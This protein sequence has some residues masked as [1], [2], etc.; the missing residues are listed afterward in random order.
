MMVLRLPPLVVLLIFMAAAAMAQ[1]RGA[2]SHWTVENLEITGNEAFEDDELK[3]LMVTRPGGWFK[4]NK[5][6]PGLFRSDLT[7]LIDFYQSNGYLGAQ[8]VDTQ[9]TRDTADHNVRIAITVD[10]GPL[11][12]VEAISLFGNTAFTDSTLYSFIDLTAGS[13]Y[14]RRILQEGLMA[15]ASLYA[16]SGY[17]EA[18]VT[19]RTKV[20]EDV[21]RVLID[22]VIEEG[23]QMVISD[24]EI[25]GLRKTDTSVVRRELTFARGQVV[26]YSAL[27]QSQRQIYLTGLFS[28]VYI[29]PVRQPDDSVGQR[30]VVVEVGEKKNSIIQ[31]SAGYGS[32]EKV[33]GRAEISANNLA[34]TGRQAGIITEANFLER[35]VEG[36]FTEPRTFGTRFQTDVS[37]L[38][39]YMDEPG[40]DVSRYGGLLTVGRKFG[41]RSN[42]LVRF[43]YENQR[44]RHINTSD[45]PEDFDPRIRSITLGFTRDSRDN[46]FDPSEG[47]FAQVTYELA[48]AFLNGT[49]A[50]N[51]AIVGARY[52]HPLRPRTVLATALEVG[53]M[54]IFG[55]SGGIPIQEL[56]FTGGANTIRA[57][58]Y[59]RVGPLDTLG[60]PIGG[61][62]RAVGNIEFRQGVW[63]WI[64]VVGF[65][66]FGNVWTKVRSYQFNSL[67]YG[68]GSGVRV[69]TPIG[70]AR[71]D[72]GFNPAPRGEEDDFEFHL[73]MGQ[74]F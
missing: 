58:E 50:F 1:D 5:Y 62:V 16:D 65:F 17:L 9:V 73:S 48:G 21:H 47:W 8:V 39:S 3:N 41:E 12:A 22:L 33:R 60:V 74:A 68:V 26:S 61:Q 19:P 34:G 27:G 4:S 71:L 36:A 28:S 10:E 13:P 70:I 66:D 57:F 52:F 6:R 18:S 24:I 11:T 72:I 23:R 69:T 37:L 15:I 64:G 44:L 67:R 35:R 53:W 38:F 55:G 40:F 45:L 42:V 2:D 46:L 56:F 7:N 63:R 25:R 49:D 51:R 29:N 31:V 43:R 59:Q 14:N 54:D 20:N 32:A 30:T